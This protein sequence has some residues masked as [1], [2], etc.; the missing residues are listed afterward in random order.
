MKSL[1]FFLFLFFANLSF[2]QRQNLNFGYIDRKAQSVPFCSPDTLSF[3]LTSPY[4]NDI[5][6]VRSIFRWITENIAYKTRPYVA[7]RRGSLR[8]HIE[9]GD[10]LIDSKPLNE[11]IALQVLK[12]KEAVCDGYSRLF[13]VLCDYAGIR[14]EIITG[15]ARSNIDR[16]GSQFKSN[17]RWNAVVLDSAWYLLDA[18][19]ASGYITYSGN[20][21]IKAYDN[22]YFLTSPQDFIRDHYPEDSR[23][24]LLADPP[25]LREFYR[26]PFK[27][28]AFNK[29]SIVSFTPAKGII[30]ASVGDTITVELMLTSMERGPIAPDTLREDLEALPH[31]YAIDFLQPKSISDKK[32]INYQYS[33]TSQNI[34]WLNIVY[35]D[36]I[37]L[38]YKLN[39]KKKEELPIDTSFK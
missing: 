22:Y 23:W 14:C 3:K 36:D 21:F 13:K 12:N 31:A 37:V 4:V 24:T 20:E 5:E 17:H 33:I 6:K 8:Y 19:W 35:N 10:T 7:S 26:T 30:E 9:A 39:I 27:H 32:R 11:R 1:F 2:S 38:R 29:Y 28:S 34:E 25:T 16:M 18:T 15:Y